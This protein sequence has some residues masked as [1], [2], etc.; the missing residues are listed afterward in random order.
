[1]GWVEGKSIH[2]R[3]NG[4]KTGHGI[5]EAEGGESSRR[6]GLPTAS[7]DDAE[8]PGRISIPKS[9]LILEIK[10]SRQISAAWCDCS[11]THQRQRKKR[12]KCKGQNAGWRRVFFFFERIENPNLIPLETVKGKGAMIFQVLTTLPNNNTF[13]PG[14]P[15][16]FSLMKLLKI[17]QE[18][19]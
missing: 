14:K 2:R 5:K 17:I 8:T 10:K 4:T 3:K 16:R 6:R 1:M 13:F 9:P 11:V 12:P 7:L 19:H 15:L 18:P